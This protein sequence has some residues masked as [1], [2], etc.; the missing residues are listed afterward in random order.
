MINEVKQIDK[1]KFPLLN[2]LSVGHSLTKTTTTTNI[3]SF[4]LRKKEKCQKV[5]DPT[6]AKN[7]SMA[8][9]CFFLNTSRL[10]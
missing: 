10:P 1:I 3:F 8:V 9:L 7:K 4:S 2:Y 6:T 5:S